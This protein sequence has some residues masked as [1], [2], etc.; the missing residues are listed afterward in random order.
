MTTASVYTGIFLGNDSK[1]RLL[2]TAKR[3]LGKLHP[4]TKGDHITLSFRGNPDKIPADLMGQWAQFSVIGIRDEG[5]A[6]CAIVEA[7]DPKHRELLEWASA[8]HVTIAHTDATRPVYSK[9]V[10]KAFL[11]DG[12][13]DG[14]LTFDPEAFMLWGQIGFLHDLRGPCFCHLEDEYMLPKNRRKIR[15][16]RRKIDPI[17]K[18]S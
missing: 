16:A 5:G 13:G 6:Q 1:R 12:P 11:D 8:P 3:H 10:A 15:N 9:T 2:S 18:T 7:V 14:D 17:P 4:N